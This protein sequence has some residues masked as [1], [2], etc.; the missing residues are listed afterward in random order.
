MECSKKNGGKAFPH[1]TH[2]NETSVD[3]MTPLMKKGKQNKIYDRIGIWRYL[4][5]F[6]SKGKANINKN[7]EIDFNTMAKH[8]NLSLI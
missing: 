4:M 8:I 7:I 3:F 2:Q 6:D 1:I 5:N